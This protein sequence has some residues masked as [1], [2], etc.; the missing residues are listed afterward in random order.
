MEGKCVTGGRLDATSALMMA[1]QVS[2]ENVEIKRKLAT[3]ENKKEGKI[4]YRIAN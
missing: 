4:I 3:S 2:G 1:S